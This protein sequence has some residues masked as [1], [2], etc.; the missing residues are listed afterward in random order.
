MESVKTG[1]D[2]FNKQLI[3]LLGTPHMLK[4]P[5]INSVCAEKQSSVRSHEAICGKEPALIEV[6]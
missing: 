5:E 1:D 2:K 3:M 4:K 6:N